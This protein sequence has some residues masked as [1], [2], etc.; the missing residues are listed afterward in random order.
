MGKRDG[1]EVVIVGEAKTK[2][3]DVEV[4][5]E[6]EEKVRIVS[7]EYPDRDIVRVLVTHFALK[8]V[9]KFAEEKGVIVVQSFEW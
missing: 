4:F 5:D 7:E 6:L 1:E 3:D 2:L 9:L 8:K